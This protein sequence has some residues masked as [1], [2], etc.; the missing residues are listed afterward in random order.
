MEA[1]CTKCKLTK[2]YS[3]FFKRSDRPKGISSRCKA[4][5]IND[6]VPYYDRNRRAI[7]EQKRNYKNKRFLVEK[8]GN[9]CA[10]C[11]QTFPMCAYD[12]HHLDPKQKE[13]RQALTAKRKERML[14]ES[15]KCILLCANCHRIHHWKE[16]Q[17]WKPPIGEPSPEPQ[18]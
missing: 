3:E 10:H 13:G 9:K 18:S 15:E 4:C 17:E 5:K 7:L 6:L 16:Q 2:N 12:F 8:F 14:Q 1:T 11:G